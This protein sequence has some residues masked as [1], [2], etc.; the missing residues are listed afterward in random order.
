[1]PG[2]SRRTL[3]KRTSAG[4]AALGT[5]IAAP[6][7]LGRRP[8]TAMATP[9]ERGPAMAAAASAPAA[10]GS[11]EPLVAYVRNRATGEIA[12]FSGSRE[13]V[14]QDSALVSRLLQT[15]S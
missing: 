1:M 6:Q 12:I 15:G 7:I 10:P 14:L 4:A 13:I 3:L 5:L 11:T 9:L 8:K 2:L